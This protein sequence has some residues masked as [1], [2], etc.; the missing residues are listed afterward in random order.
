MGSEQAHFTDG[1]FPDISTTGNWVD[2]GNYSQMVL[3]DTTEV[4]CGFVENNGLDVL[5][6]D[7]DPPGNVMGELA[8]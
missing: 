6:C 4:G 7:Y 5:V 8:Y 2:V 1:Y 3:R